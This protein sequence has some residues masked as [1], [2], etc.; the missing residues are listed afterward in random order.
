MNKSLFLKVQNLNMFKNKISFSIFSSDIVVIYGQNGSGKTTILKKIALSKP[1]ANDNI[2]QMMCTSS[3][4]GHKF[5][6]KKYDTVREFLDFSHLIS[7]VKNTISEMDYF[8]NRYC[9]DGNKKIADLSFGQIQKVGLIRVLLS[10]KEL[11]IL[12]EPFSNIDNSSQALFLHDLEQHLSFQGAAL[13]ATHDVI[14]LIHE[15]I[16]LS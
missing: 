3:Y 5:G 15:S 12:D 6:I 8:L 9:L 16:Y 10:K 1:F 13:I 14:P 11:W 2:I 7:G 4:L